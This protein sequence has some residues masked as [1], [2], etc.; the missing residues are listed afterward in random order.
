MSFSNLAVGFSRWSA[1][2]SESKPED[3]RAMSGAVRGF[4]AVQQ[5]PAD[6]LQRIGMLIL[7][8]HVVGG[9][10]AWAGRDGLKRLV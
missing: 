8:A 3:Y 10:V 2:M 5:A 1:P 7:E 4:I 9:V 6:V